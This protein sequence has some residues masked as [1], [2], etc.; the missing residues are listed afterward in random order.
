MEFS[1]S[2]EF[3]E[4]KISFLKLMLW[5][6]KD[7]KIL[8]NKRTIVRIR[9]PNLSKCKEGKSLYSSWPF[10]GKSMHTL[11]PYAHLNGFTQ[12]SLGITYS[13][14]GFQPAYKFMLFHRPIIFIR[15]ILGAYI[16]QFE[17]TTIYLVKK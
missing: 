10:T 16:K 6:L 1:E 3:S 14:A 13:K 2:V 12:T 7:L 17:T 8:C 9:V 4:K 5:I 15:V 11:T